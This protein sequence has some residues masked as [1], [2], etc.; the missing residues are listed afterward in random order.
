VASIN[1]VD[2]GDIEFGGLPGSSEESCE[3]GDPEERLLGT[4]HGIPPY[5][6]VAIMRRHDQIDVSLAKVRALEELVAEDQIR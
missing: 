6:V 3:K 1:R 2:L 4:E 5:E